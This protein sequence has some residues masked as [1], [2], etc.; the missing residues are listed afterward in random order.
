MTRQRPGRKQFASG[1]TMGFMGTGGLVGARLN[2]S[3][4]TETRTVTEEAVVSASV[5]QGG[6][7]VDITPGLRR[8]AQGWTDL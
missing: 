2:R 8:R 6:A 1:G 7:L 4:E 5:A 3:S